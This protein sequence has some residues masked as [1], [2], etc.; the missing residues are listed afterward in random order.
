[1][2]AVA[3]ARRTL[4]SP[5]VFIASTDPFSFGVGTGLYP[6]TGT[7]GY[8]PVIV[9]KIARLPGVTWVGSAVG[10]NLVVMGKNGAPVK[11]D[12]NAGNGSGSVGGA[13]FTH[14]KVSVVEGRMARADDPREFVINPTGASYL[15][16]HVGQVV[17]FGA[18][19]NAQTNEP[20]F[21]TAAV[22]PARRFDLTLVGI[23]LDPA[24]VASDEADTGNALQ[25]FTP[26]LTRQ[27]VGCCSNYAVT[28]V[29]VNGSGRLVSQVEREAQRA[30]PGGVPVILSPTTASGLAKAERVVKPLAIALGV[31]G[32]IAGLVAL[33]VAGQVISRQLRFG[34][35]DRR[36]LRAL[37]SGPTGTP[38]DG[39]LG[40]L[41]AVLAGSLLAVAVAVVLSPL[42]PLGV[43]RSVYPHRGVAWDGT[44][45]G[46]GFVVL[47]VGLGAMATV[48]AYR[49]SPHRLQGLSASPRTESQSAG[50][51]AGWGLPVPAVEGVR[52]ALD[53]GVGR[54]SV[55]VRSAILGTV[56]ALLV[57]VTT[58]TFGSSLTTLINHPDLYGWNW[59]YALSA[60]TGSGDIPAAPVT[61][62][63]DADPYVAAWSGI[64]FDTMKIDG[65]TVPVLGGTP[66]A[67][68]AASPA[69]RSRPRGLRPGGAGSRHAGAAG[70]AGG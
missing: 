21:G 56:L 12:A 10:L 3:G 32:G 35:D 46:L 2:G 18:Y 61:R 70:K 60:G 6:L 44:V 34:A 63:L 68:V 53:G 23:V 33:L 26:A 49:Q 13:Y 25:I 47:A 64:Y 48:M 19:T 24:T 9:D 62:L 67:P 14:D 38:L 29:L 15:G 36:V 52:L 28:G 20:G 7:S 50:V 51:A 66:G 42:A 11:G 45:L 43:I 54:T 1:M 5:A 65:Q 31:F 22:L 30:L 16:L 40:L 69:L 58:V 41:M 27:I 55:P 39:L 17:P 4:A 37:G 57:V 59:D 8:D